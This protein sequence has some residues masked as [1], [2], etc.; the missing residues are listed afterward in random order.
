MYY[1]SEKS[2]EKLSTAH[3]DLQR[4]FNKVIE[5]IDCTIVFGHRTEAEQLDMVERGYSRLLFPKSKHNSQP[6]MAIDAVPYPI[7][8]HN[9]ERF[10]YFAGIVQ[11]IAFEMGIK[12]RWGGDWDSDNELHDQTWMDLPHFE[13]IESS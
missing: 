1:F 7:D 8:W 13:L 12:I 6:S 5:R 3:P 10:V 2:K 9:R 11:G 4:L